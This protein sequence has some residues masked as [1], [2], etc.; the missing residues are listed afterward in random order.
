VPT[1]ASYACFG[2][3]RFDGCAWVIAPRAASSGGGA[4]DARGG[5]PSTAGGATALVQVGTFPLAQQCVLHRAYDSFWGNLSDTQ[6]RFRPVRCT[7]SQSA[8]S[9]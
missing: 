1:K 4:G 5:R 3:A 7:A 9:S 6:F 8:K 2:P